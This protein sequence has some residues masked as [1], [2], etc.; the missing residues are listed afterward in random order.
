MLAA[1]ERRYLTRLLAATGGRVS[2]TA[3][4]AGVNAR[5]LFDLM[6]RHGLRKESFKGR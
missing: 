3:T 2:E 1:L 5:T 6:R 4:R